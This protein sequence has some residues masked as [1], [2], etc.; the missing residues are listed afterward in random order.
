MSICLQI[1]INEEADNN[2]G[3]LSPADMENIENNNAVDYI[4]NR[5]EIERLV[6]PVIV[7]HHHD[8]QQQPFFEQPNPFNEPETGN[9]AYDIALPNPNNPFV[10]IIN[11]DSVEYEEN[12][13][14]GIG[15]SHQIRS[16][17]K[18]L[19][20]AISLESSLSEKSVTDVNSVEEALRALD[21]A[22]SGEESL[23]AQSNDDEFEC[24]ANEDVKLSCHDETE[25]IANR[26]TNLDD[27]DYID[28]IRKE[29]EVLVNSVIAESE[30]KIMQGLVPMKCATSDETYDNLVDDCVIGSSNK[31]EQNAMQHQM[32]CIVSD[33]QYLIRDFQS[34]GSVENLCFDNIVLE[35]ST[36][37]V[38]SKGG[39]I[40]DSATFIE[41]PIVANATFDIALES[42]V[43]DSPTMNVIKKTDDVFG[44]SPLASE[45]HAGQINDTKS[46]LGTEFI[47]SPQANATFD[48]D[49]KESKGVSPTLLSETRPLD[50]TFPMEPLPNTNPINS[51]YTSSPEDATFSKDADS[52]PLIK[53]DCPTIK[54]D[55]EDSTSVDM[56]TVTP[57]N[58]PIELNYSLDSWD[59]FISNS[60]SQELVMP[61][62]VMEMQPCTSA[63][64]AY[65]EGGHSSGWFLHS[66]S[67]GKF[68]LHSLH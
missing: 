53:I 23:F 4:P 33:E 17:V 36:P 67:D 62:H 34:V 29:A 60:M 35:A 2:N 63:Q 32:E 55:R 40:A 14:D 57:V 1:Q 52:S 16:T 8:E 51:T 21:Y 56:T 45:T 30:E 65:A 43:F 68:R 59:Q 48:F 22:I 5:N 39:F 13:P 54:I 11:N 58:T 42:E 66:K 15:S 41:S 24:Y 3:P 12:Q 49:F 9:C 7:T 26:T 25:D 46:L 61:K 64:A 27:R 28:E 44:I 18:L 38:K 6:E 19:D 31:C 20:E 50:K 10:N 47:D 37:F